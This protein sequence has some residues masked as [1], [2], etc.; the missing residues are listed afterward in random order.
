MRVLLNRIEGATSFADLRTHEGVECATFR[1][2]ALAR[3]LLAD[4]AE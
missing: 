2:A 1:E 4:D 3:G